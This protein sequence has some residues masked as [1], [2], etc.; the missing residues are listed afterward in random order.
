MAF[1]TI[2]TNVVLYGILSNYPI[3]DYDYS[4]YSIFKTLILVF[5]DLIA[6]LIWIWSFLKVLR[7]NQLS[8]ETA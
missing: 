4:I 7:R 5:N 2:D 6:E 8:M 3:R 1:K